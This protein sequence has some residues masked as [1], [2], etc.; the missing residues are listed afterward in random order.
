MNGPSLALACALAALFGDA[1]AAGD[2]TAAPAASDETV[3]LNLDG[4]PL[5]KVLEMF[6]VQ[7]HLNVVAGSDVS[8]TV[9]VNLYRVP[10][11]DALRKVL[12]VNGYGFERDGS[13]YVVRK[14][15]AMTQET[16]DP[17]QTAVIWLDYVPADEALKMV[18][19]LKSEVGV[20][21]AGTR[22][23]QG[24]S[25][26]G[27]DA[28]G[29]SPAAGEV[30]VLR[31]KASVVE[32]VRAVLAQLDRKPRQVR[33]EATILEVKLTDET[34]LGIDFNTLSG[35]KFTDAGATSNFHDI[36][37]KPVSGEAIEDGF[38]A[39]G[40][41]G[42]ASNTN[43]DGLHF[44]LVSDSVA[45]FIDAIERVTDATVLANPRLLVVDRQR[46]EII[47]GAKLGYQTST[48]T[49]TATV[50]EV[51]FL[52][53]GTQ[54]RFRPF[55]AS[56]GTVRMEI[57]PENSTGVVDP[58]SGLPSE[59]TTEVTTN[60]MVKDGY[61]I[62]IGGLIGDQVEKTT[63][64]IP[65]LGSI[66]YLGVL[67][68]QTIDKVT[69]R[70]VI[71]LLTPHIIDPERVD[72]EEIELGDAMATNR[73]LILRAHLPLSRIKLATRWI[74]CADRAL[75]EGDAESALHYADAALF[76]VPSDVRAAKLRRRALAVVELPNDEVRALEALNGLR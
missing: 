24:L 35:I 60:I 45:V 27:N 25:S 32:N 31:D 8:G 5:A 4:V 29:N 30:I 40:S 39:L 34:Q 33:I 23:T 68:R 20:F 51:E 74:D 50:Q 21:T 43:T 46:A 66:P 65:F 2:D 14:L 12:E 52:D 1:K 38:G 59:T 61:T 67:F 48:T 13:F 73:D 10:A 53:I 7:H 36:V 42:F 37:T 54:L 18:L 6:A 71:V 70:E 75:A 15:D 16:D 19:P 3:T 11:E 41:A 49:E 26:D 56:D 72:H 47:I 17:T 44:G 63:K 58:V 62:A 55:I 28:G 9:T 22:A 57:H 76:Y 64:Q 69:R